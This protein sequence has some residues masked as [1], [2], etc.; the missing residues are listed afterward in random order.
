[1]K[2]LRA[3]IIVLILVLLGLGIYLVYLKIKPSSSG[4]TNTTSETPRPFEKANQTDDPVVSKFAEHS[5]AGVIKS[6]KTIEIKG[7][8]QSVDNSKNEIDGVI[9]SHVIGILEDDGKLSK[10]WLTT[11][12]YEP[13]KY[14]LV[15]NMRIGEPVTLTI[16]SNGVVNFSTPFESTKY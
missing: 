12:Q 13:I 6:G 4:V 5:V 9:Y 8:F 11:D 3:L 14:L 1:M 7:R 16:A 10:T 15:N 2:Y